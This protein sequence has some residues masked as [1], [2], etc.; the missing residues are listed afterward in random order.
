MIITIIE[1]KRKIVKGL[2]VNFIQ[3]HRK[4][5][6]EGDFYKKLVNFLPFFRVKLISLDNIFV[7][8]SAPSKIH[9]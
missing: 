7:A 5:S 1:K 8:I 9:V 2:E 3:K 6:N 4:M